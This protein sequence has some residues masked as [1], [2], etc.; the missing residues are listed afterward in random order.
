VRFG[1]L[2]SCMAG[3]G[4]GL[5]SVVVGINCMYSKVQRKL[6][7]RGATFRFCYI[8]YFYWLQIM[9]CHP[10]KATESHRQRLSPPQLPQ[11][12]QTNRGTK[13][14][15]GWPL[16]PLRLSGLHRPILPTWRHRRPLQHGF[17][18]PV[19]KAPVQCGGFVQSALFSRCYLGS[20]SRISR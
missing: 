3:G 13:P 17:P 11:P 8:W 4:A 5:M 19:R 7:F 14:G 18:L 10:K 2:R 9:L 15:S 16:L 20:V 1:H 12:G 6:K